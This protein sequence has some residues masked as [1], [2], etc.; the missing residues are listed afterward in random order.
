MVKDGTMN[1]I[2]LTALLGL[3][4]GLPLANAQKVV[5]LSAPV[6]VTTSATVM[7][8]A[9][10]EFNVLLGTVQVTMLPWAAGVFVTTATPLNVTYS[11]STSPT[12]ASLIIGLNK[13]NLSLANLSLEDRI[14]SQ[15]VSS[16]FIAGT[17]SGTVP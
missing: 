8:P 10:V 7:R 4:C 14:M 9:R 13:A 6:V 11:S 5:T 3:L 12:G 15:L 2:I 17:V 16:G 1:R